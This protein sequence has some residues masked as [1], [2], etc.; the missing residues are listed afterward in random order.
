V[1]YYCGGYGLQAGGPMQARFMFLRGKSLPYSLEARRQNCF[2]A[3]LELARRVRDMDLVAEIAD[4]SRRTFNPF[5][6]FNPF[7]PDMM[8]VND[9]GMDEETLKKV[10]DFERRTQ[11]YPKG[12]KWPFFGSGRSPAPCQ[13]PACRR[14]RGEAP[15]RKPARRAGRDPNERTLFDDVFGDEA[16]EAGTD[17][18]IL[19][20]VKDILPELVG[21]PPELAALMAEVT[22]VNGGRIPQGKRELNQI[23]ARH[24]EIRR[25]IEGIMREG[26]LE[27]GFDPSDEPDSDEF[28][29]IE[30]EPPSRPYQPRPGR[31]G[32]KKRKR[33]R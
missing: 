30:Y 6:G 23:I 12:S 9:L 31:S 7:G 5:G 25:K 14:A 17:A 8:D 16:A 1:A 33:R 11:K 20:Q 27:D 22:R 3:A 19:N 13:C 15:G 32:R 26:L 2:A 4:A 18:E 28:P 24:P 21:L 29:D 10:A